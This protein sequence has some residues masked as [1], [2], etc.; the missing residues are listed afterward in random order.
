[1]QSTYKIYNTSTH[2]EA[3]DFIVTSIGSISLHLCKSA[4]TKYTVCKNLSG[5]TPLTIL[6]NIRWIINRYIRISKSLP[7]ACW[8]WISF[9]LSNLTNITLVRLSYAIAASVSNQQHQVMACIH[10][11]LFR[12]S[13]YWFMRWWWLMMHEQWLI[14]WIQCI[15]PSKHNVQS[16]IEY[17]CRL[18]QEH[19]ES[20][21]YS[22]PAS[23]CWFLN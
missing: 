13:M 20:W 2:K 6:H 16:D 15:Q 21:H 14:E 10:G 5:Y 8:C 19:L 23:W 1:M 11:V 12:W 22:G 9:I 18:L 17:H 3:F 4:C 7:L